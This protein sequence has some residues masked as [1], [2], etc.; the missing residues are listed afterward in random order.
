M[1]DPL[2]RFISAYKNRVL[3]HKDE[4]FYNNTVSEVIEKLENG[5]IENNHFL[6]QSYFFRK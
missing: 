6:P 1:R 2:E 3:F 4:G 5:K